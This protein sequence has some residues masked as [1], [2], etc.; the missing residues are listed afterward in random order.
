MKE[1]RWV[2]QKSIFN[3][4][5]LAN[6]TGITWDTSWWNLKRIAIFESF[7]IAD[8]IVMIVDTGICA[9]WDEF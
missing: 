2:A 1:V 4:N 5:G 6:L 8:M 9:N 7:R 3:S